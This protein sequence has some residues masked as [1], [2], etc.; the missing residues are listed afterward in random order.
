[1]EVRD[2]LHATVSLSQDIAL[3]SLMQKAVWVPQS[4]S[5]R[6]EEKNLLGLR[7]SNLGSSVIQSVF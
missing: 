5:E 6:D 4:R 2:E 1:M 7:E 3:V